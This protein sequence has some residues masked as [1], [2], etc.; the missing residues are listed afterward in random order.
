MSL[1]AIAD[2]HL[3]MDESIEDKAMDMFG[4]PWVGHAD[5]LREI[6]L[7]NITD[8]DTVLIPGDISWALKL[9]EVIADFKWLAS[10]PG[11]KIIMK[12]NHDLW[13]SSRKKMEQLFPEVFFL[14]NNFYDG[15]NCV[16]AGSRGW[17]CPGTS[18]FD[19]IFDT[20][21]YR[22][23]IIRMEMS[24]K[25]A[26]A[27]ADGRPIIAATHFPPMNEKHEESDFTRLFTEYN[28]TYALY[29]HLHGAGGFAN[30]FEGEKNGV[31]YKLVSF[32]RLEAAPF[33]VLK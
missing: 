17:L 7:R 32:D 9:E 1:Y 30:G 22:R 29:G 28:V 16:I 11:K 31:K 4:G 19:E 27:A 23:E 18:D 15:G 12:G 24:L 8:E 33:L 25:A 13:W 3:A 26:A 5:R 21:V 10:L 2:L 20:K 14:Q 6:W